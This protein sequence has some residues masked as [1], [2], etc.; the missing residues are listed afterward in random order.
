MLR[1]SLKTL[2]PDAEALLREAGIDPTERPE[3]LSVA[4]F[5]ALAR[6]WANS[7]PR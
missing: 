5:A 6:A 2:T 1:Q 3:Q 7:S 4:Q